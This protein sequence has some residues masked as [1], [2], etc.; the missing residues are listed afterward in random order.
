M[1]KLTQED[2]GV[3]I[4]VLSVI[5]GFVFPNTARWILLVLVLFGLWS[6]WGTKK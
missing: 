6:W 4:L 5:V 3:V 1:A 2:A